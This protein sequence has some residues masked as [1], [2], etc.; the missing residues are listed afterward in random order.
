MAEYE[1]V[2]FR[3]DKAESV[4]SMLFGSRPSDEWVYKLADKANLGDYK[5]KTYAYGEPHLNFDNGFI[6]VRKHR[7]YKT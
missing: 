4:D 2:A 7:P 1:L 6:V 5:Y 3:D